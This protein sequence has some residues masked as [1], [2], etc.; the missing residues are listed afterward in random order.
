MT[1]EQATDRAREA[2]ESADL[3]ALREALKSRAAAI[4]GVDDP[5]RLKTAIEAGNAIARDLR[6]L[7]LKLRI[8]STRLTQVHSA[9]LAQLRA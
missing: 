1:L 9:L 4:A 2:V 3:D 7:K 8:D 6:L 5:E